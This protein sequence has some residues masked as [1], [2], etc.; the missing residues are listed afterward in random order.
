MAMVISV[1]ARGEKQ[2]NRV[3]EGGVVPDGCISSMERQDYNNK[4]VGGK[5]RP[6]EQNVSTTTSYSYS[7]GRRTL[8]IG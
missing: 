3:I 5:A 8:D 4:L 2:V 6:Q 1:V 7:W